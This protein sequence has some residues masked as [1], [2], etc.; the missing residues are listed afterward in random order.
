MF[1][2]DVDTLRIHIISDADT[3]EVFANDR[4]ALAT[5]VYSPDIRPISLV[6]ES[7]R[8][9]FGA[10]AY[11][12]IRC[13]SR[14]VDTDGLF[15]RRNSTSSTTWVLEAEIA[16]NPSC[17]FEVGF[18]IRHNS[19]MLPLLVGARY[20]SVGKNDD[21]VCGVGLSL[22]QVVS[23]L[24]KRHRHSCQQKYISLPP[25]AGASHALCSTSS[26]TSVGGSEIYF[27]WQE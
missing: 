24:R 19:D 5:M 12:W 6:E 16:I 9:L 26:T 23:R 22:R 20:I 14:L 10:I 27:C 15:L 11:V 18:H 13:R 17:C 3:L 4:F 21:G 2:S 1:G 8:A 25:T 7:K